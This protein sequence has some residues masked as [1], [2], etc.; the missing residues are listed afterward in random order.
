MRTGGMTIDEA[1]A[2]GAP[3]IMA[4]L[5]G[6]RPDEAVAIGSALVDAGIRLIEI[7]FNSP[8]PAHSVALMA[9]ALGDQA[10]IGGGTILSPAMVDQLAEAGGRFMVSPNSDTTVLAHAVARGV[11]PVPGFLTPT[12]AF[13]AIA[14]GALRLKLFPGSAFG[15]AY[16]TTLRDVLPADVGLWAVGG[17]G[18][19]NLSEWRARGVDGI[20]VGGALYRPGDDAPTVRARAEALV[21]A[22]A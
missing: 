11:E 19:A 20:G 17:V 18:V 21:A 1:L 3:P 16:L 14:A 5:R 6:I 4:I 7:P 10:A 15:P 9:A 2:M 8:D 13:A 22:W 12:E